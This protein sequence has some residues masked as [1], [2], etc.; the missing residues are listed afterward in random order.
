MSGGSSGS[1]AVFNSMLLKSG[2]Y[3][4]SAICWKCLYIIKNETVKT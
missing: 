2:C 3:G 1:S 4:V